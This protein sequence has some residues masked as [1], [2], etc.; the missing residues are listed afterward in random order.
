MSSA[1]SSKSE[2]LLI[3]L[4]TQTNRNSAVNMDFEKEILETRTSLS[5]NR[6]LQVNL[7]WRSNSTTI[8][9][10]DD[11]VPIYVLRTNPWNADIIFKTGN[12]AAKAM[13]SGSGDNSV[14]LDAEDHDIIGR[15]KFKFF[16]YK[17][18]LEVRGRPIALSPTNKSYTKFQY[19]SVAFAANPETTVPMYWDLN[20]KL[21]SFEL[22]LRNEGDQLVAKLNTRN[23]ENNKTATMELFGAKAWDPL[24]VEEVLITGFTVFFALV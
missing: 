8:T 17:S 1:K 14:D 21:L 13:E 6:L 2:I 10:P 19:P 16:N 7:S 9:E 11:D 15:T 23:K 12:A 4:T 3:S 20:S 22:Y 18:G 24:A 5:Q